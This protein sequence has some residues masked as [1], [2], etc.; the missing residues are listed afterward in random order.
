[1]GARNDGGETADAVAF[2]T[3][4]ALVVAG[5][6]VLLVGE[7][8]G[9]DAFVVGGG[10]VVLVGVGVTTAYLAWLPEPAPVRE[11]DPGH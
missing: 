7:Y 3:G 8:G 5:L 10:V 11:D 2:G 6:V 1:M 9:T 4:L